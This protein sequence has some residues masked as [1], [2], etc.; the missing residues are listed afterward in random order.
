M[1][2]TTQSAVTLFD[3]PVERDTSMPKDV[4]RVHP[5]T[6]FKIIAHEP[7]FRKLVQRVNADL[8]ESPL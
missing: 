1:A 5:E 6:W 8:D 4:I 3:I 2:A 7:G